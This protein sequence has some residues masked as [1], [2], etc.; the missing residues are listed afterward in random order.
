MSPNAFYQG[1]Y[2]RI[3]SEVFKVLQ[4]VDYDKQI[5]SGIIPL[6]GGQGT[7]A[8]YG[9]QAS[10]TGQMNSLMLKELDT[11]NNIAENLIKPMLNKWLIY[12]YD[13]LEPSE[14][15]N[16]TKMKFVEPEKELIIN[17]LD[18]FTIDISTQ[19]TDEIKASELTFM[20]Q[21]LGNTIPFDITKLMMVEIARLK[22]MP[23]LAQQIKEFEPKPDPYEEQL[24]QIQLQQ[25]QL[26]L[27]KLQADIG[28]KGADAQL[29]Q[30]KAKEANNKATATGLNTIK[31]KYGISQQQKEKELMMKHQMDMQ[32]LELQQNLKNRENL[33]NNVGIQPN[34]QEQLNMLNSQEQV[35]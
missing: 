21:T 11:I 9:S 35:L 29:K 25:A 8:I 23:N 28:V 34:N 18:N 16:I 7:Q 5:I 12:I 2:N 13:L 33:P 24:K 10:K 22:K 4:D 1:Q 15:E 31:E 27:Q 14:I 32:K 20:M 17:Y 26:E 6:Q 30:A 3:P 19:Q